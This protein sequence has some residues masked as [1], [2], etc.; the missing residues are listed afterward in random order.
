MQG[1]IIQ[2]IISNCTN[3][4]MDV[5]Y[6]PEL[7]FLAIYEQNLDTYHVHIFDSPTSYVL[8]DSCATEVK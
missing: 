8:Q 4:T 1:I 6:M 7:G 5:W 3:K 2:A